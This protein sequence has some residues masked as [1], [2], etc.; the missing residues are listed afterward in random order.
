MSRSKDVKTKK[1]CVGVYELR[2]SNCGA[3][4]A[5][6]H[7]SPVFQLYQKVQINIQGTGPLNFFSNLRSA[8]SLPVPAFISLTEPIFHEILD[9]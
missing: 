6:K 4:L 7:D 5:T 9:Y 3:G 1:C 2:T 8:I